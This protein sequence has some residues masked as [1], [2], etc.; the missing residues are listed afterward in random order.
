MKKSETQPALAD[1][2]AATPMHWPRVSYGVLPITIMIFVVI[3]CLIAYSLASATVEVSRAHTID[4]RLAENQL[5]VSSI[6]DSYTHLSWGSV[7]RLESGDVNRESWQ[8]FMSV[9]DLE[10]NFSGMEAIG[11][12]YGK[13]PKNNVI[14]YVS[15]E[16]PQTKQTIDQDVGKTP[17]LVPV[18]D[19]AARTGRTV[20]SDAIPNVFSTKKDGR[21]AKTGFLMFT[22]FYDT[23]LPQSDPDQRMSALR[24]F[25]IAMFRGEDFFG[26]IFDKTDLSHTRL[27]IYLGDVKPSNLL[28]A[29]G[30][31]TDQNIRVL[32]QQ[33][34]E[35]GK[36]IT[37]V[38]KMDT[39]YIL[40]WIATYFPQFILFGGIVMG[41][42][43]AGVAGYMLRNR[44]YR[45]TYEKERDVEF[46]KDELL[47]LA[48][49][50]L[51]TPATGVKQYLGMVLQG[52]AGD[53][54]EKQR[55]YLQRAY[56]SNNRQLGV[57][58]DI[59]HLAKLE[60][61]RIVLAERKFDL[62]KMVRDVIDEQRESAER[63]EITLQLDA[64]PHGSIMGDSHMLRMVIENLVSNAIKYTPTGGVVTVRLT[65]R[66]N[67]WVVM[68]KD[69]GVGIAKSDF[70]KLFKQFSRINNPRSEF[71]TGTG[72]GLY[73]A[74]HLTVLHGG[75]VS[76]ASRR[77]KGSTFTVRLPRKF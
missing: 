8:R 56:A 70:P 24:G 16:T 31:N 34:S 69:T 7:G 51:R 2:E 59:L 54:S 13:T 11:V 48:S 23:S 65:R 57:I 46:A 1:V 66:A 3:A 75:T 47:S 49:H 15:P 74:Y 37:I 72:V 64:P 30:K 26:P 50:Q 62:A 20:I 18:M 12:S 76:V 32:R 43:F 77:G 6:F 60:T 33:M 36:P 27:E 55:E 10:K 5:S 25:T 19:Q 21:S 45:L 53:I 73:L 38:N 40:T 17:E 61:G 52:F 35:Y 28:Y 41:L 44:F 4:R 67:R 29:A 39:A 63:G 14:A 22:P 58:N 42:L 9:Y 68:V 71:V